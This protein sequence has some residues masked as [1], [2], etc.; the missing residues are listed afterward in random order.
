MIT[1]RGDLNGS[2]VCD[3][4]QSYRCDVSTVVLVLAYMR[5][6]YQARTIATLPAVV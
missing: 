4:E 2:W 3:T 5:Y 1:P 6:Q